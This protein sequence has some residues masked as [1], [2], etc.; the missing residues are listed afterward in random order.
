[1][2]YFNIPNEILD[3]SLSS[4]SFKV[5]VYIYTRPPK[6]K[7]WNKKVIEDIG[8]SNQ[9]LAKVWKEL[10]SKNLISRERERYKNGSIKGGGFVYEINCN[11]KNNDTSIV[12]NGNTVDEPYFMGVFEEI[13]K[14][15][16]E[17]RAKF[18]NETHGKKSEA[19]K[20]FFNIVKSIKKNYKEADDEF[21]AD[22]IFSLVQEEWNK[23][24]T[25]YLQNILDV[26]TILDKISLYT[27]V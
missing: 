15:H 16:R 20:R 12:E 25:P 3:Y 14:E 19:K 18:G 8:I 13:W 4:D 6:W 17:Y 1:M 9:K 7:I 26:E 27:Q 10:L 21:I 11:S 22:S 2:Q 5:L 23:K 24:Y